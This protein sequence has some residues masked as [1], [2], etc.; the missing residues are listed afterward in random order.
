MFIIEIK[1]WLAQSLN[2]NIS[3]INDL[4]KSELGINFLLVWTRFEVINFK[5]FMKFSK[6]TSF[7]EKINI[8]ITDEI[9]NIYLK[10]HNRYQNKQK[11]SNLCKEKCSKCSYK[12]SCNIVKI[13]QNEN[14][15]VS[16]LEKIYFLIYIIYRYRNNMFH[17]SKTFDK[18]ATNYKDQIEDCI[19]IM[20]EF[21][22]IH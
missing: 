10:F 19:K 20:M 3:G 18:W 7:S 16:Y 6:I 14:E 21:T 4:Y 15:S 5:G 1:Q 9:E 2:T 12:T 8:E 22:N 17:G 13:L 11:L